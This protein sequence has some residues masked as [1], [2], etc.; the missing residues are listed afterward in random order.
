MKDSIS[1]ASEIISR[2]D[3]VVAFTG[4]GISAES[5]IPTFRGEGGIW[6]RFDPEKAA[7]AE[8]FLRNPADYWKLFKDERFPVMRSAKPNP[9][10]EALARLENSGKLRAVITQ[11]ID[12][13]HQMAGSKHVIELHGSAKSAACLKCSKKYA[14][15]KVYEQLA[16]RDV[17][18]CLVCGGVLKTT[19][20]LFGEPLSQE[21]LRESFLHAS[22]CDAMLCI[23]SSLAVYPAAG[24][25]HI[26]VDKGAKLIIVNA[27]PTPLDSAA[28]VVLH[29]KAGEILPKIM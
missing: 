23:G 16:A 8:G 9:G 7:S 3:Y 27:E 6:S 19:V 22:S 28:R 15:E 4:A 12:G 13:L 17:P 18:L 5:G 21:A 25:P 26:A 24:I 11:N 10:H 1:K 14:I 29:G 2:S 20:V